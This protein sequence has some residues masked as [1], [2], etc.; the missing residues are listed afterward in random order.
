M[1]NIVTLWVKN[2]RELHG[3]NQ[4][5]ALD[6]LNNEL[7]T[8][9]APHRLS[10]WKLERR[11]LPLQ[12]ANYMIQDAIGYAQRHNMPIGLVRLPVPG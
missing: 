2:Q 8:S 11:C 10:E 6:R 1:S 7:H 12:V 5:Q 3:L 9:H 4:T